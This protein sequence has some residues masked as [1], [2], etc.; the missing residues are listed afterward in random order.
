[1]GRTDLA[2]QASREETQLVE[3]LVRIIHAG[4]CHNGVN[5]K[6][7]VW[8]SDYDAAE[9]IVAAGWRPPPIPSEPLYEGS[10]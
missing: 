10:R 3:E 7:P 4:K 5:C 1:M 2:R 6:A 8:E 9:V